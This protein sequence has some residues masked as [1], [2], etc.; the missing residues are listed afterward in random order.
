MITRR[1][2]PCCPRADNF[3]QYIETTHKI[4]PE[5][6]KFGDIT[7]I[8]DYEIVRF[9][10]G[11]GLASFIIAELKYNELTK[12]TTYNPVTGELVIGETLNSFESSY[13]KKVHFCG[14]G[15][16]KR[17]QGWGKFFQK[18]DDG[19]FLIE[20]LNFYEFTGAERIIG[21][22]FVPKGWQG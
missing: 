21:K 2:S 17:D 16:Y 9:K 19:T 8:Y 13:Q 6:D 7:N 11:L 22:V 3:A 20:D 12:K 10:E 14:L 15:S 5:K 18:N 1:S 4:V